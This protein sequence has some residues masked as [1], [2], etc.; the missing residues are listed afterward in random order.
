MKK[1]NLKQEFCR[2]VQGMNKTSAENGENQF[3][4]N[5]LSKQ[6]SV[7]LLIFSFVEEAKA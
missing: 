2:F 7:M 3:E 5:G 1:E 4:R 6:T